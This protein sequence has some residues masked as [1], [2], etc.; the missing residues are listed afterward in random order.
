MIRYEDNGIFNPLL[1]A[2]AMPRCTSSVEDIYWHNYG[3]ECRPGKALDEL[4]RIV[5]QI[6]QR[7]LGWRSLCEGRC[8]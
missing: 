4:K 5:H 6:R 1:T 3:L 8:Q 2:F 7:W